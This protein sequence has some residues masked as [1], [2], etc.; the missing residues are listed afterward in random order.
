MRKR[1]ALTFLAPLALVGWLTSCGGGAGSAENHPPIALAGIDLQIVTGGSIQLDGT[2]SNDPDGDPITYQWTLTAKPEGSEAALLDATAPRPILSTDRE[3]AYTVAL[4]VS[5]GLA[6]S[7]ADEVVV[8]AARGNARPVARA[9]VDQTVELGSVVALDATESSDAD[10][11]QLGVTWTLTSK[12]PGSNAG[13]ADASAAR[14][15]FVADA[16]GEFRVTLVVADLVGPSE[17]DEVVITVVDTNVPPT[18]NAGPDQSVGVGSVVGIDGSASSDPDGDALIFQWSIVS[19]P[20]GSVAG[21]QDPAAPSSLF[22]ADVAGQFVIQLIVNDGRSPSA[23]DVMVVDATARNVTPT[24]R[25]GADRSVNVGD[26]VTLDGRASTDPEASPL[27]YAWS[28][29]TV[30]NGSAAVLAPASSPQPSFVADVAGAY[31]A[32]LVVSDGVTASAPDTVTI[33]AS[34]SVSQGCADPGT[35]LLCDSLDGSTSGN[36][37]GGQFVGDGWTPGWSIVWDLGVTLAEGS[38]SADLDNW[39]TYHTSSQHHYE[40]QPVLSMYEE[41][42]GDVHA[43]D[44]HSTSLWSIWTGEVFNDLFKFWSTT[45]GYDESIETR[46]S[47]PEGRLDPTV[48][49]HVRVEFARNGAATVFLDGRSVVTHTHPQSFQLRYVFIGSDNSGSNYGPQ[50]GVIYKN[51]QVWG[52]TSGGR[53]VALNLSSTDGRFTITEV[54]QPKVGVGLLEWLRSRAPVAFGSAPLASLTTDAAAPPARSR[55]RST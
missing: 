9:G 55:A 37:D 14:T 18:A 19:K 36:R 30:P 20:E 52:S 43:A 25:A 31:V 15:V 44:A 21:I 40:K 17:P 2:A 41:A 34:A 35:T 28:F 49:H 47:P 51:V 27:G 53:A 3:G 5:D 4:V 45:R 12:P 38:F 50:S 48:T 1:R 33:T 6:T 24:A 46:H 10:G 26:V 8:T 32:R 16:L 23:P 54:P 13:L 22:V 7:A 42:H 29:V 39:D 11:D